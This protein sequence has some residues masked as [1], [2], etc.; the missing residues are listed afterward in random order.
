MTTSAFGCV[1]S[2]IYIAAYFKWTHGRRYVV[3]LNCVVLLGLLFV[4]LYAVLGV[5]GVTRQSREQV[6]DVVGFVA[7]SVNI[8]LYASP[9]ETV[10]Q[11]LKTKSAATLP[12]AMCGVAA[13]NCSLWLI[14]G[15]VDND[16]FI[17]TPNVI[18]VT[19]SVIQ[20][21]LYVIYNPKRKSPARERYVSGNGEGALSALNDSTRSKDGSCESHFSLLISPKDDFPS[22]FPCVKIADQQQSLVFDSTHSP[23]L[24]APP[25]PRV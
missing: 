11:V 13:V 22:T 14:C 4:T 20:V 8:F 17:V 16:M 6:R 3:K 18:G 1:S 5:V 19:L 23:I 9:F 12:I 21:K 15:I 24:L 7:V 2:L 10:R 25:T